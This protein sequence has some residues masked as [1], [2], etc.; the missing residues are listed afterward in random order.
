MYAIIYSIVRFWSCQCRCLLSG[1][2]IPGTFSGDHL[3]VVRPFAKMYVQSEPIRICTHLTFD[4]F[5]DRRSPVYV[6]RRLSV[7]P[8][9]MAASPRPRNVCACVDGYVNESR[10]NDVYLFLCGWCGWSCLVVFA[11]AWRNAWSMQS[12]FVE[13]TRLSGKSAVASEESHKR[14][15]PH[16]CWPE[17]NNRTISPSEWS[18]SPSAWSN[19]DSC[20]RENCGAHVMRIYLISATKS[21]R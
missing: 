17:P 1:V 3:D 6:V 12:Q 11:V 19:V 18:S 7:Y 10:T 9:P 16:K 14:R 15:P 2:R 13:R 21:A 8:I 5:P 20:I 4:C